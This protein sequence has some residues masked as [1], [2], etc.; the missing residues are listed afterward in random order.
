MKFILILLAV[1]LCPVFVLATEMVDINTATLAQLDTLTGIGPTY[2]QRIID[3][4]PYSLL[5][6]L[7]RVKG[8]GPA[9]L[10][11]I[12]DQGL[13]CVNCGSSPTTTPTPAPASAEA[14]AGKP[15]SQTLPA[16]TT[17][18]V[19]PTGVYINEILPNPKGADETD[20]WVVSTIQQIPLA[21]L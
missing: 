1:L 6:D 20:E 15:E 9:T 16:T 8:I 2:A 12:K 4:R 3:G 5:D 17:P 7:L 14:S 11:K 21:C 10:Q 13:A 18:Q 19:Y